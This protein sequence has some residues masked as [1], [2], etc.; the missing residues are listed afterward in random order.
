MDDRGHG[1]AQVP[2]DPRSLKDWDV[3][4]KDQE[5]FFEHLGGPVIA[6]GHSR[7]GVASLL[8]TVRRPDLIDALILLDP[9][10]PCTLRGRFRHL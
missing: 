4:A 6:M 2:A 10:H 8:L 9:T 1:R 7:G 3:F 5:Q